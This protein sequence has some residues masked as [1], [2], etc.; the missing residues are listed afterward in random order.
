[1]S[2]S[3][4]NPIVKYALQGMQLQAAN[5]HAEALQVFNQAQGEASTAFEV[6]LATYFMATAQ[7]TAAS[8]YQWLLKAVEAAL[9]SEDTGAKSAL[10]TLYTKLADCCKQL[11]QEKEALSYNA[12]AAEAINNFS[13]EGPF[14]HGTKAVLQPGDLLQA[15]RVSNYVGDLTMNHIYFTALLPGASL[16][17]AL[18]KGEGSGMVYLVEPSGPFE[19]D[20]NVTDKKFP[21]NLTRSYRSTAPLKVIAVVPDFEKQSEASVKQWREKLANSKG[22]IIN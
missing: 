6:F 11:Q 15:G 17:A 5:Q 2:F 16:A 8:Q 10:A 13:D 4:A 21:G 1:M 22:A 7:T 9:A 12:L 20:P 18:A 3:P 19:P 14:Y